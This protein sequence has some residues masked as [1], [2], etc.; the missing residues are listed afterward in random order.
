MYFPDRVEGSADNEDVAEAEEEVV[1]E[2]EGLV[3]IILEIHSP[4][5]DARV[6]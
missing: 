2:H 1:K 5:G 6:L 4:D 3:A